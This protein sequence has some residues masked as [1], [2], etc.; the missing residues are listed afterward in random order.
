[1]QIVDP[2]ELEKEFLK[3]LDESFKGGDPGQDLLSS[4][5]HA[6]EN[7]HWIRLGQ[8]ILRMHDGDLETRYIHRL[9]RW[10]MADPEALDYY[11]QFTWL[12]TS[13]SLLYNPCNIWQ[14]ET[15][16]SKS[17]V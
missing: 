2:N 16:G 3:S 14:A 5:Q 7:P 17:T 9:E 8:L 6:V 13:L 10:L 12:C 11:V 1:M 15:I 4:D